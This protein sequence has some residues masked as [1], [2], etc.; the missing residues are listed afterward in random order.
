MTIDKVK[1]AIDEGK[2]VSWGNDFF[3]GMKHTDGNY[4]MCGKNGDV[5]GLSDVDMDEI[6][7]NGDNPV[8]DEMAAILKNYGRAAFVIDTYLY[9][10]NE[11]AEDKKWDVRKYDPFDLGD[12]ECTP[13]AEGSTDGDAREALEL[14]LDAGE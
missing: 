12:E 11:G 10:V 2:D 6:Y 3:H 13:V 4:Y 1:K 8:T 9:V 7:I 5:I 14:L